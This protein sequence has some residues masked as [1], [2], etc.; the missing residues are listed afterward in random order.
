MSTGIKLTIGGA[1]IACITAYMAYLGARSSWQ[2]YLTVDECAANAGELVNRSLRV[3]GQIAPESLHIDSDRTSADFVLKGA[4]VELHVTCGGPLPDN[5]A[6][7]IEVVVEGRLESAVELCGHK[8]ITRCASKYES[9]GPHSP[10]A[11]RMARREA[12]P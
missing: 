12:T 5:L 6:E 4:A 3:S 8:V 11:D 9:K 1:I 2:Y 7:Q 10:S